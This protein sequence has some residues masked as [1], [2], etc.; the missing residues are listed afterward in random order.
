MAKHSVDWWLTAEDLPHPEDRVTLTRE[1][2]IRLAL[3]DRY[4]EHFH[5]LVARWT[6]EL[7]AVDAV[8]HLVPL[9][10]YLQ[11]KI[12]TMGVAHQNGTCRFGED[13]RTSVLTVLPSA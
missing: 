10:L 5:R 13:P 9:S 12:P 3:R 1:G 8:D 2:G 6:E 4:Q 11:K 7:K